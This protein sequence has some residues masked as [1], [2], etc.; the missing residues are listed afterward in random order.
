[1]QELQLAS[2]A[3]T[4][5]EVSMERSKSFIKALQDSF[6]LK[7]SDEKLKHVHEHNFNH[8]GCSNIDECLDP[9]DLEALWG[10]PEVS[11]QRIGAGEDR[12]KKVYLSR[13]PDGQPYLTQ[14]EMKTSERTLDTPELVDD[15]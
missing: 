1:M 11:K 10:D 2:V 7:L 9:Q 4:F 14:T 13:D 15:Y 12:G 8:P 6:Y 3:K 5:D